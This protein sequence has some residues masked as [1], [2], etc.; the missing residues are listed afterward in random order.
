M[1]NRFLFFPWLLMLSLSYLPFTAG[2]AV[3]LYTTHNDALPQTDIPF[4]VVYLDAPERLLDEALLQSG[5][6]LNEANTRQVTAL[7]QSPAWQARET[8]LQQA[9]QG[10][11][12]AWQLG[13][14][15]LPAV[16]V[17]AQW[18]VYGS[19]DIEQAV[20][21]IQ[22]YRKQQEGGGQP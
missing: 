5:T 8:A 4:E 16:V 11:V 22:L 10:V 21:Q 3:V 15:R 6:E 13:V 14:A 9:Y 20:M 18:V 7:L 1:K 2:A 12:Q 19:T 17:D